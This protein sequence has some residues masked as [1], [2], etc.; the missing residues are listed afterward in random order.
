MKKTIIQTL[1]TICVLVFAAGCASTAT[2]K[3][4]RKPVDS[5]YATVY[6]AF[7]THDTN[8]DGYLDR[9]EFH[10]F[11]QDPEIIKFRH[12]IPETSTTVPL[13]FEEIDENTD[14]KI[15]LQEMTRIAEDYI[16]KIK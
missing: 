3:T 5:K 8:T 6:D 16:P 11:Q 13:L 15:S 7:S 10:Q 1:N 4:E 12:R 2:K 14:N 9:H